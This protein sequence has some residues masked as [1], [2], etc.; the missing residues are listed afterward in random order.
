MQMDWRLKSP[1]LVLAGWLAGACIFG[2][3]TGEAT[4]DTVPCRVAV[5]W[6]LSVDG[7]SPEQLALAYQG[8]QRVQLHWSQSPVTVAEPVTLTLGYREQR[9]TRDAC[10]GLLSVAVDFSL[11]A[12]DGTIIDAGQGTLSTERG[13]LTPAT[14]AASGQHFRVVGHFNQDAGKVIVSGTL[15]PHADP[16]TADS[17]DFSSDATGFAGAGGF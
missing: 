14:F 7:V 11:R 15:E 4:S 5:A 6:H 16:A 12:D 10:S 13:L 8:E 2:G 17:A 1:W 9:A 3:Q